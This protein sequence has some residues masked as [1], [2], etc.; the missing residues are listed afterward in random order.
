MPTPKKVVTMPGVTPSA[1]ADITVS[2]PQT[3]RQWL[4]SGPTLAT[5]TVLCAPTGS[6]TLSDA[7]THAWKAQKMPEE[8]MDKLRCPDSLLEHVFQMTEII[9]PTC[10][11][12]WHES[13]LRQM[14]TS[15]V[16][17]MCRLF[18][19]ELNTGSTVV[20]E[21]PASRGEGGHCEKRVDF[22]IQRSTARWAPVEL[23]STFTSTSGSWEAYPFNGNPFLGHMT[24]KDHMGTGAGMVMAQLLLFNFNRQIVTASGNLLRIPEKLGLFYS[25]KWSLQR[26]DHLAASASI[27][28]KIQ[29]ILE[30]EAWI[31][32]YQ[33]LLFYLPFSAYV[34]EREV[35]DSWMEHMKTKDSAKHQFLLSLNPSFE[36][37]LRALDEPVSFG[38][39]HW[40]FWLVYQLIFS[41]AILLQT[42]AKGWRYQQGL[43]RMSWIMRTMKESSW[44]QRLEGVGKL[45]LEDGTCLILDHKGNRFKPPS[46]SLP[47]GGRSW[48]ERDNKRFYVYRDLGIFIKLFSPDC[49][50]ECCAEM[51][52]YT[53]LE[54][55]QGKVI[56]HLYTCGRVEQTRELFIMISYEGEPVE[57]IDED[58]RSHLHE[59][60]QELHNGKFHHHDLK[61][62]NI[63]AD[64]AGHLKLINFGL[65][66]K[67][68]DSSSTN[69]VQWPRPG[70]SDRMFQKLPLTHSD[71]SLTITLHYYDSLH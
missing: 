69:S 61:R 29:Y 49:H 39:M 30:T 28:E 5:D 10:T 52:L 67:N 3:G 21:A 12:S 56:P 43:W 50:D 40:A 71:L 37:A 19:L 14:M 59:L 35:Y 62:D 63:V 6:C 31:P 15:P 25:M 42:F 45:Y 1:Y 55:L 51:R 9:A 22:L 66:V 34:N 11:E 13:G 70:N 44:P 41:I 24:V 46:A 27:T 54:K 65:S 64:E 57:V 2:Q 26:T 38:F 68:C 47:G 8:G 16:Q 20:V 53:E 4:K 60:V 33:L 18:N 32:I 17:S 58:I 7:T 36:A 23:K 48:V